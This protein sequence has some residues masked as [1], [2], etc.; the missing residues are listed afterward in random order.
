MAPAKH[1][2]FAENYLR[3]TTCADRRFIMELLGPVIEETTGHPLHPLID[4][5]KEPEAVADFCSRA[6]GG[7]IK[8]NS[9]LPATAA[10]WLAR[11]LPTDA[12]VITYEMPEWLRQFLNERDIP[13]LDIRLS[14]YRFARDLMLAVRSNES[15]TNKAL[16]TAQIPANILHRSAIQTGASSRRMLRLRSPASF[17]RF[18]ESL[19][20]IGQTGS[21][22]ALV[23]P[24]GQLLSVR[25]YILPLQRLAEGRK[26]IF[27]HAHPYAGEHASQEQKLLEA[28]LK[29]KVPLT[30]LTTSELLSLDNQILLTGISSGLLQEA[31]W[32]GVESE[33]LYKPI[34]PDEGEGAYARYYLN[35]LMAPAF[36]ETILSGGELNF[37]SG[38]GEQDLLRYRHN[39]WFSHDNFL[40][41]RGPYQRHIRTIAHFLEQ[42][43]ALEQEL[44]QL[45]QELQQ[46][47]ES[48][49]LRLLLRGERFLRKLMNN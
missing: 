11:R 42:Q 13:W 39:L 20:Y 38:D 1:P 12:Y 18:E 14:P 26:R 49:V 31:A 33:I 17:M 6:P 5:V 21:D 15:I 48:R 27:Y 25:D 9:R 7:W 45:E 35:D 16:Q 36:W 4:T 40:E 3:D 8:H 30:G 22:A 24:E 28:I 10:D 23:S 41:E 43:N 46:L 29:C 32:F 47:R 44:Q 37:S 34:C 2:V 19:V